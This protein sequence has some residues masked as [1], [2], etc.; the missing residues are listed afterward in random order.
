MINIKRHKRNNLHL[1]C[2][3]ILLQ[4]ENCQTFLW[5]YD[6]E[7]ILCLTSGSVTFP[8]LSVF[9][10]ASNSFWTAPGWNRNC[11]KE[12]R[13]GNTAILK[14]SLPGFQSEFYSS[15]WASAQLD[16]CLNFIHLPSHCCCFDWGFTE[17]V[18]SVQLNLKEQHFLS[19]SVPSVSVGSQICP[20][21][22]SGQCKGAQSCFWSIIK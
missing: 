13:P 20:N 12:S 22:H 6:L 3:N 7:M 5:E 11:Y 17:L 21:G 16:G 9:A 18:W 2:Q 14:E 8:R 10:P 19:L 15:E 1:R 4:R